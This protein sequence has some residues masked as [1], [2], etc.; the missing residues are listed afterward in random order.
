[1][2]YRKSSKTGLFTELLSFLKIKKDILTFWVKFWL[3]IQITNW[4]EILLQSVP[5]THL[6]ESRIIGK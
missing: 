2:S 6:N 3:P 1:M 5:M 4:Q